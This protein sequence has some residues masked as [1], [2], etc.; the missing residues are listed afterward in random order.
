[1]TIIK[2]IIILMLSATAFAGGFD[3]PP[4]SE[5]T[6]HRD[7]WATWYFTP[8]FKNK[9]NGLPLLDM[10]NNPLGVN[11]AKH[12]WCSAAM[13]GSVNIDGV[14]FNYAGRGYLQVDCS[15]FFP[16]R[17]GTIRYRKAIGLYGDGVLNYILVPYRTIAVDPTFIPYGTVL[18]IPAAVGTKLQLPN[19][20]AAVH[21]GYFFAGDTGGAILD[22]HFDVFIGINNNNPFEFISNTPRETH[23]AYVI[24]DAQ[25]INYMKSLHIR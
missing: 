21:D 24:D 12:E 1:M 5:M 15:E 25:I 18:Y 19:G 8:Q 22:N 4:P 3:L 9:T 17:V 13:E 7:I 6:G 16:H 14:T 10:Q 23:D 2:L 11:L 20:D